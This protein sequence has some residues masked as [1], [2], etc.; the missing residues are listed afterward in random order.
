MPTYPEI[1]LAMGAYEKV[2]ERF[3]AFEPEAIHIATEGPDRAGGAAHLP[4]MEAAVHHQ[5][6]H[7]I[8]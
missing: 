6:S 2:Q 3:K 4:G 7:A 5:L 1:K 8:P